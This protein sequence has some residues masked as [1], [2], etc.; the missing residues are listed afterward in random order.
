M[1]DDIER[2][3]TLNPQISIEPP[4]LPSYK[5]HRFSGNIQDVLKQ[6]TILLQS[7]NPNIECELIIR[8]PSE[9]DEIG[10]FYNN[11]EEKA[12]ISSNFL[13]LQRHENENKAYSM[14][15]MNSNY[16]NTDDV[17]NKM[18]REES[19]EEDPLEL[20]KVFQ[21]SKKIKPKEHASRSDPLKSVMRKTS[22]TWF[23]H[24]NCECEIGFHEVDSMTRIR[25]FLYEQNHGVKAG[26]S[27]LNAFIRSFNNREIEKYVIEFNRENNEKL[28]KKWKINLNNIKEEYINRHNVKEYLLCYINERPDNVIL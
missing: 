1:I 13:T 19:K 9:I 15:S 20:F 22:K 5:E 4:A 16:F 27:I 3:L 23:D 6:A 28:V 21:V 17:F 12:Y 14:N 24:Y 10:V 8:L 25:K 2:L 26:L 11:Q 18:I 7:Q